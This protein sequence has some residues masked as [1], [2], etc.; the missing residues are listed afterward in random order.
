[1]QNFLLE[2]GHDHIVLS[3][4]TEKHS[5]KL[6]RIIFDFLCVFSLD[7]PLFPGFFT[8]VTV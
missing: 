8:R 6:L 7:L 5:D 1:M 2:T 4:L 3:N